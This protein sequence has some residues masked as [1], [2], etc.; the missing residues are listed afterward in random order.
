MMKASGVPSSAP[1]TP[2]PTAD[3]DRGR[4]RAGR[5]ASATIEHAHGPVGAQALQALR[6][7]SRQQHP[8]HAGR[9][10]RRGR[11]R[12][13][14]ATP[15]SAASCSR[16]STDAAVTATSATSSAAS[17]RAASR[18]GPAAVAE[19]VE[20]RLARGRQ[21]HR[22]PRHGAGSGRRETRRGRACRSPV[23]PSS[24][25]KT[26]VKTSWIALLPSVGRRQARPPCPSPSAPA[27]A[28][29]PRALGRHRAVRMT[30]ERAWR[31]GVPRVKPRARSEAPAW[32]RRPRAARARSTSSRTRRRAPAGSS[33][34]TPVW[35]VDDRLAQPADAHRGRIGV[36][37]RAAS[38]TVRHQPSADEAGQRDPRAQPAAALGLL[39]D[40]AVQKVTRSASATAL[41]SPRARRGGHRRPAM[42]SGA[43]PGSP[44]STSSSS[45]MRLYC[46]RRPR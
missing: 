39:V 10:D 18:A 46:F 23:C 33:A 15:I 14:P 30:A 28:S 32:P 19:A 45:S 37:A 36:R 4:R 26:T 12:H 25:V 35:P 7:A 34:S 31:R 24:R 6:A 22:L 9:Q 1:V 40:V 41:T 27:R 5:R 29:Q 16:S 38:S 20:R 3:E 11:P 17:T 44:S 43:P 2:R 8:Q 13:R 21:L 42:S